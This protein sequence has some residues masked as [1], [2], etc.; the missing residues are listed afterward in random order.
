MIKHKG[1]R[2]FITGI[3]TSGKSYLAKKL[4]DKIGG[5]AVSFDNLR[6]NLSKNEQ[7]NKWTN[8]YLDKNEYEYLTTTNPNDLWNNLV[9]QS[10]GLWSAFLQ[11]I[12]KYTDEEKPIIFECV[13]ILPHMAKRDLNFPGIVLLGN[14]Y[15]E[16][17]DTN[18][19]NPR[20]GKTVE[21][22]KL[23]AKVFFEIERPRYKEEARKYEYPVFK[24]TEEAF[25]AALLLL[26]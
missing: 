10:E 5:F 7:Y 6:E 18:I 24:N 11:E 4:T 14:S 23:E 26:K 17:L 22:Q 19:K 8:F 15:E 3:P 20:W 12:N 13:N 25:E 21:L 2:L 9:A 16:I 1:K